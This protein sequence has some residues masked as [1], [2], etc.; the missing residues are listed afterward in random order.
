MVQFFLYAKTITI[1]GLIPAPPDSIE[2]PDLF[3]L[4]VEGLE[5]K[6]KNTEKK[7]NGKVTYLGTW[8]SHPF[9]GSASQTDKKTFK[10]L[11]FVRNYEPT[12][13]LIVTPYQII[14]V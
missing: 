4:G 6:I 3:I 12:I 13:C 7:T 10:K 14:M 5:M 2:R 9:G 11:L 1:T 8:H